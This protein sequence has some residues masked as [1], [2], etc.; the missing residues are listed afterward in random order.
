MFTGLVE[1]IGT[2][3]R[4]ARRGSFQR[5]EIAA[6]TVLEGTQVGD[7]INISGACQ[8]VVELGAASFAV[9]SVEETLQR[10]T[11]GRLQVGNPVNL[12]R[13]LRLGDRLGGHL[14]QGHVDG[15][16]RLRQLEQKADYWRLS[17]APPAELS[18]YIAAKGSITVDGI[19]LTVAAIDN[20]S[21]TVA[22][23]PHTFEHTTLSALGSRAELNLEVDVIARYTERLL[24]AAP[25]EGRS[26][27]LDHL[28]TLGY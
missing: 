26:L 10:T 8:T 1:E 2:V 15:V 25:A 11:L 28:R 17:I 6:D 12:E 9:E 21:F 24:T 22:V 16:G 7:S 5:L 18:P 3:A 13:A 4:I 23:I 14:V 20:E 19:S 27:T